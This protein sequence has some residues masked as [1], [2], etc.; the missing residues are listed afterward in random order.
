M[1][2]SNMW[3]S[4][5]RRLLPAFSLLWLAPIVVSAQTT[6]GGSAVPFLLI[7]P[8]ARNSAIGESGTGTANDINATFWNIGGLAYQKNTQLG[9]TYSKWLPQFNADLH[10]SYLAGSTFVN[11]LDGVLSGQIT[12]L[13]LGEFQQTFENGQAGQKFRSL[14]FAIGVGYA[15]KLSDDVGAGIQARFIQSNL[16]SVPVANEQGSGIGRSVGFDIGAIWK[17]QTD[18]GMPKDFLSLGATITNI[19]PKIHYIDIAQADPLP[20]MFRFGTGLHLVQDEFNDLTF[21]LDIAKLLVNRPSDREVD[22]V[23][24]SLVTAWSNGKGVELATGLEYWYEQLVALR[25]G[26][27]T[28]SANGGNREFLT[29]GA[30]LRYD[31]YG[32][33]FSYINTIEDTHPLANTLRFTLVVDFDKVVK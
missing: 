26:Y 4:A 5:L 2:I 1:R 31:I 19:G 18:W 17:P 15:T 32:F 23:P 24:K 6:G 25:A 20:T 3:T 27:F 11:D 10:Y 28:E 16:S 14:E 29:F 21:S 30:G 8:N 12:F 22:P 13:D 33:D 7:S 9:L